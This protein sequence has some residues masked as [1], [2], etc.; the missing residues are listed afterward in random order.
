MNIFYLSNDPKECAQWHNNRHSIKM[1]VELV[2]ILSTAH[3]VLDGIEI[4]TV[5]KSGR[6]IKR[7]KL[8]DE[9]DTILYKS[10]HINHPSN[11]WVRESNSNYIWLH[12]LLKELCKEYT[13]RYGKIHKCEVCGLVK[14]LETPPNNIPH[15]EFTPVTPAMPKECIIQNDSIASYRNY[16][17]THKRHLAEWKSRDK[18]YW[19]K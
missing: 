1:L 7:W 10:T 6:K 17:I 3:R 14:I 16:Y 9:R 15:K 11:L 12:Q 4:L 13:Y 5:S 18:P 8:N 19:Y 2:Q